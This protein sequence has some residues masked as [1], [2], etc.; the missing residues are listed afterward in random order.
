LLAALA[1][2]SLA[3]LGDK[4]RAPEVTPIVTIKGR[5]KR[6]HTGDK[7]GKSLQTVDKAAVHTASSLAPEATHVTKKSPEQN[8]VV[9]GGGKEQDGGSRSVGEVGGLGGMRRLA[10][11][12]G[13]A[14][15]EGVEGLDTNTRTRLAPLSPL[16][17]YAENGITKQGQVCIKLESLSMLF[18]RKAMVL[19]DAN[20]L[21][22]SSLSLILLHICPHTYVYGL[23]LLYMCPHS[24][25]AP[26]RTC[27]QALHK[28]RIEI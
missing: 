13:E 5:V 12:R 17:T 14:G 15:C 1:L 28:Q 4:G 25:Q 18:E 22:A 20:G 10:W 6:L 2:V 23:I 27:P 21:Q 19:S 11:E 8:A 3:A 7:L 16:Q 24:R 9:A 26:A